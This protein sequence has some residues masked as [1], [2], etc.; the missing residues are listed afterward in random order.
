[1]GDDSDTTPW[2]RQVQ[3]FGLLIKKP[4]VV[5][6]A[7]FFVLKMYIYLIASMGMV[8]LPT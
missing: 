1:M 7:L 5:G 3:G 4:K 2:Q 8:Y 6:V